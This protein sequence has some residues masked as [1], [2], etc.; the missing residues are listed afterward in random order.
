MSEV[1][2]QASLKGYVQGSKD[3][4][5]GSTPGLRFLQRFITLRVL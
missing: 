2:C 1:S 4:L 5:K 3:F